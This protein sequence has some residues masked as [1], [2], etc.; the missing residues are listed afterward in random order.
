M[1]TLAQVA[2]D[3]ERLVPDITRLR[4]AMKTMSPSHAEMVERVV[5]RMLRTQGDLIEI[6]GRRGLRGLDS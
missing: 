6:L 3:V 1:K 2:D 5:E 4:S